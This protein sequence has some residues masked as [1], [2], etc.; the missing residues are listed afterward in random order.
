M[1][2]RFDTDGNIS[3]NL[4]RQIYIAYFTENII[5]IYYLRSIVNKFLKIITNYKQTWN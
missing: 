5:S 3:Q 2:V 1:Y 4:I